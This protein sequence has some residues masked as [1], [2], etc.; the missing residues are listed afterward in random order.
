MTSAARFVFGLLAIALFGSGLNAQSCG[1]FDVALIKPEHERRQGWLSGV[2]SGRPTLHRH[3][4]A[5]ARAHHVR[6]R[7]FTGQISGI[8]STSFKE[9]Y[10][11]QA[12]L[13]RAP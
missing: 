5:Y 12:M 10:D 7:C 2:G 1:T 6:L 4:S 8:P 13:R 11:I 9:R 3:K